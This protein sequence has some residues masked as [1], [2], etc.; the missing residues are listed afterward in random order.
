M[1]STEIF[2]AFRAFINRDDCFA[3]MKEGQNEYYV[4]REPI[5]QDVIKDHVD[6][7][8]TIG[9]FQLSKDEK[10]K[11]VCWDFDS[12]DDNPETVFEDAKKLYLFL[13]NSGYHPLLEFSGRRGYH[14]WLFIEPI[15]AKVAKEFAE[16][17]TKQSETN[18]DEI[19]PKQEKLNGKGYGSMVK[20]PLGVHRVS[21]RRSVIFDDNF[22]ELSIEESIEFL[23]NI[24]KDR[25]GLNITLL[26]IRNE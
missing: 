4:Y 5:T 3:V 18:P 7:L 23:K 19:F 9:L 26:D 17:M 20:L 6:G 21:K 13:K 2:L 10:V 11:W 1:Q 12:E 15:H 24:K 16:E 8:M 25:I 22:N 14:V